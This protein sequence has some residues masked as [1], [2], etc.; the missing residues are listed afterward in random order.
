MRQ[1]GA[2]M[3]DTTTLIA[4]D[5]EAELTQ[6]AERYR[7]AGGLGVQLL[8]LLGGTAENLLDRLPQ[9]VRDGL[10]NTVDQ[11]LR[12]AMRTAHKS[13]KAVPKQRD[14]VNRVVTTAMGAAGGLG[15][16]PSALVE[17]PVTTT[18]LL[19]SIQD[20]AKEYGFNPASEN[21]QFDCIRVFAA[22]GPLASDDGS[23]M[24][25]VSV[26]L[27]LT[28]GAMN[29]LLAIVAPRLAAVLGQKLAAQAVPVLGAVAG[30]T[31]NYVYTSYYQEIAHVHFGLRRLA[32]DTD[33]PE[34]E[35]IQR[36]TQK[37]QQKIN[38]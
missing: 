10:G 12:L 29:K 1:Q 2:D 16:L 7:A 34:D 18:M 26:R 3:S 13:R 6:L 24:G 5:T 35:L 14:R 31:A 8:N 22:A 19:R 15:G 27:A 28:G 37:M 11:A 32:I 21:I 20:V 36:L 9:N 17:L 25:F 23:D 4:V 30:A 33:I 38:K